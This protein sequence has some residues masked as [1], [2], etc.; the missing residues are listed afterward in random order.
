MTVKSFPSPFSFFIAINTSNVPVLGVTIHTPAPPPQQ[1]GRRQPSL[2][3][4]PGPRTGQEG[5]QWCFPPALWGVF[6]KERVPQLHLARP[7]LGQR[8]QGTLSPGRARL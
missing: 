7:A 4:S 3:Q 2:L 6:W 5:R 1:P 8:G